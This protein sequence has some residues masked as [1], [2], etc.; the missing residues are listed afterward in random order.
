LGPGGYLC[1][2]WRRFAKPDA[3]SYSY[4]CSDG[5]TYAERTAQVTLANSYG[6]GDSNS[7]TQGNT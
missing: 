1:G 5:H 7:Y 3:N 4:S 6:Y 2:G